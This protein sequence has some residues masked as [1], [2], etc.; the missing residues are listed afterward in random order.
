MRVMQMLEKNTALLKMRNYKGGMA[1]HQ[2]VND[3]NLEIINLL[4]AFG[5]DVNG[6]DAFG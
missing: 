1:I 5:S 2:A 6:K 4:I 3:S